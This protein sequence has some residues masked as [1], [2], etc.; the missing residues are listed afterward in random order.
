MGL[1]M[2][3]NNI[4][5]AHQFLGEGREGHKKSI[6]IGNCLKRGAWTICRGLG[7]KYEGVF[8]WGGWYLDAHYDLK[9]PHPDVFWAY[10][11]LEVKDWIV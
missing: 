6:Y 10:P 8:C 3:N 5:G 7:K 4:I 9:V 1:R 2:K 11:F